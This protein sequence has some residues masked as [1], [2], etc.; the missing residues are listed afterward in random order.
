MADLSRDDVTKLAHLARINL[1]DEEAEHYA[2]ELQAILE[3]VEQLQAV[4]VEGL[5]PTDQVSG[6]Q[7]VMRSDEPHDYGYTLD[8]LLARSL[9]V[10]DR[11]L[12]VRRMLNG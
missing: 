5:K 9:S 8:E 2:G 11:Q 10:Q 12:K 1:K 6:L 4:D 3:Y 7:N